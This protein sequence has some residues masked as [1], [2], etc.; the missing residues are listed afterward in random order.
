LND[1]YNS[2]NAYNEL[3]LN[4]IVNNPK[5]RANKENIEYMPNGFG[6]LGDIV[7]GVG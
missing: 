3:N 2:K 4:T 1:N 5:V 7:K 6:F